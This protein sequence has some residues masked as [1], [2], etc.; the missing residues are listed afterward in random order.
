MN[1]FGITD[2]GKVRSENQDSFRIERV[3][4]KSCI[5]AVLCDGM[6]GAK[7][8]SLASELAADTF[9]SHT[10]KRLHLSRDLDAVLDVMSSAASA[11]NN[12]VFTK[13][14]ESTAYTGMGTTLV[15]ALVSK[16]KAYV[17]NIGDSRAYHIKKDGMKQITKDHSLVQHL[18]DKGEITEEEALVHPKRNY[19]TKALGVS[20]KVYGDKFELRL[21][22][23]DRL[24]LCSDGLINAVSEAEIF[25][26]AKLNHDPL[27][28][29]RVLIKRALEEGAKDNVTIVIIG[30]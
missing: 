15:S 24:M 6:G 22:R 9:M 21:K 16:N 2:V 25:T 11:S 29:G 19:I 27:S 12:M 5:V 4:D 14:E 1:S 20:E 30:R 26:L 17:L 3:E 18:V 28:L 8:G 10:L 23:G 13:S 7:A